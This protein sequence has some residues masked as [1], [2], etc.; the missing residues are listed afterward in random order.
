M[1]AFRPTP[2]GQRRG[3]GEAKEKTAEEKERDLVSANRAGLADRFGRCA[4]YRG[5]QPLGR[6]GYTA[7]FYLLSFTASATAAPPQS[8]NPD[9]LMCVTTGT[10]VRRYGGK[11][12]K[13]E[14]AITK[15]VA[16]DKAVSMPVPR[17]ME[18]LKGLLEALTDGNL[19]E[20]QL[21][22]SQ[23]VGLLQPQHRFNLAVKAKRNTRNAYSALVAPALRLEHL[24]G[25]STEI[26]N[27]LVAAI[28]M[29][30]GENQEGRP[31]RL[32]YNVDDRGIS[33]RV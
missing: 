16:I 3:K 24:S 32:L 23:L 20:Q 26:W 25:L 7:D 5:G 28:A 33:L 4:A 6:R 10:E 22:F 11:A 18:K 15:P 17:G 2:R 13:M 9:A 1:L 12:K 31:L 29:P 27:C 8:S 14:L 21:V 19:G 30:V